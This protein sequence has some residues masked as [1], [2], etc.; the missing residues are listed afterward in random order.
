MLD[1][2]H[3]FAQVVDA[4][5][6]TEAAT[7][8][9]I[10]KSLV[11]KQVSRL[12]ARLQLRLLNRSTRSLSLTDAGRRFYSRC[13]GGL[14]EIDAAIEDLA[15]MRDEPAGLLRINLP[16]SFGV[17]HVSPLL[18]ALQQR[19]PELDLE[20]NLDD[21]KVELIEP[22]FDVSIRISDLADSSM[23]ARRLGPCRHLLVASPEYVKANPLS[24]VAGLAEHRILS[25]RH[26]QS[27]TEW[28]F[29]HP[30]HGHQSVRLRPVAELNNSLAIKQMAVQGGG[31]A[32]M[33]SFAVAED[34]CE[35]RLQQVLAGYQCPELSIFAVYPVRR[36]L[37]PKVRVFIDFMLEHIGENPAWDSALTLSDQH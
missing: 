23:V 7:R 5:S 31:I 37:P 20:V 13:R 34:I 10:S 6:F 36:Y 25:Y 35:G 24:D 33:P 15:L 3:V 14:Q 19:F 16:M 29:T 17:M 9:N 32:R 28:H 30:E 11:S 4:G 8:L 26:Q 27:S 12:E 21:R 22:A 18:P 1:D 2:I